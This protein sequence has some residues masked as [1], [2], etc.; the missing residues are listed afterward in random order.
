MKPFQLDTHKVTLRGVF[1]PTGHVLLM[2]PTRQLTEQAARAVG[3][4]GLGDDD[5]SLLTPETIL[6][7]IGDTLDGVD[8]PFP[9]AGSEAEMVRQMVKLAHQ[10]HWG[11]LV[12]APRTPDADR[13]MRAVRDLPVAMAER[14]RHLVIEDL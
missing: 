11:L 7:P 9:S 13:V 6:G 12:H 4:A 2:L 14:Y 10:G 8:S 3:E 1:Y 5:I